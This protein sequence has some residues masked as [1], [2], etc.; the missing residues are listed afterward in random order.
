MTVVGRVSVAAT[1][2]PPRAGRC[3]PGWSRAAAKR[4]PGVQR[5]S[6]EVWPGHGPAS[7]AQALYDELLREE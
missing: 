4:A 6:V 5:P 3:H 2:C 1:T 7:E